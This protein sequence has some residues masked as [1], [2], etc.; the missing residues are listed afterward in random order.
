MLGPAFAQLN[1]LVLDLSVTDSQVF[2]GV[3]GGM[4]SVAAWTRTA[5]PGS[6][7]S[8]PTATCR[9]SST[10][11]ATS[12]SASTTASVATPRCGCWRPTPT[13]VHRS[14]GTIEPGFQPVSGGAVGVW[15]IDSDGQYLVVV[16]K[17]PKMGGFNVKGISIHPQAVGLAEVPQSVA[18]RQTRPW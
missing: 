18:S 3:D 9:P 16:G 5:A 12:T 13:P 2:A 10:T 8:R 11:A 15:G 6:G 17:F 1:D 7:A 14:D 4:N